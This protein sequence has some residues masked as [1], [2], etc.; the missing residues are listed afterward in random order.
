MDFRILTLAGCQ[1]EH[2]PACLTPGY[3]IVAPPAP[4]ERCGQLP[5][6]AQRQLGQVL[7]CAGEAIH[8]TIAPVGLHCAHFGEA[9]AALRCHL[10]PRTRQVTAAFQGAFPDRPELLRHPLL[11]HWARNHYRAPVQEVWGLVA[12]FLPALREAL[13]L[14]ARARRLA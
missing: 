7:Q 6:A 13:L 3:L 12:P 1:V 5:A 9:A 4:A 10:F 14:A 11:L 2:C 8:L